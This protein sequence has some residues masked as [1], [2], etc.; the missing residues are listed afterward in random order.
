MSKTLIPTTVI[1]SVAGILANPTTSR[2]T[3]TQMASVLRDY[4]DAEPQDERIEGWVMRCSNGHEHIV[5]PKWP[6]QCPTL[7]PDAHDVGEEMCRFRLVLHTT[8]EEP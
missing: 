3:C 5:T 7:V 8:E 6:L 1:E 2:D 4:L